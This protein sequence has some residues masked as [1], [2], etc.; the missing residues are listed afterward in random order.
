MVDHEGFEDLSKLSIVCEYT[1]Y[2]NTTNAI[3]YKISKHHSILRG[4][5][6]ANPTK[7]ILK[8]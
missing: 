7:P 6:W 3:N 8:V 5:E 2:K 1:T 4:S